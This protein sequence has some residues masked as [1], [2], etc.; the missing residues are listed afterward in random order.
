MDMRKSSESQRKA[1]GENGLGRVTPG[2]ESPPAGWQDAN[3]I[4]GHE[5]VLWEERELIGEIE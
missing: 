2:K 5:T 1:K 4:V 3:N